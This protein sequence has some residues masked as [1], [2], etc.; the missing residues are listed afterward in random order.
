[1]DGFSG[2]VYIDPRPEL[3]QE[4]RKR[5]REWT[6]R[7]QQLIKTSQ[8]PAFTRDNRRVEVFANAG[9]L[10]DA[11]AAVQNGAEGIGLLRT[12]FLFLTRETPPDEAEQFS[13]LRE[14]IGIMGDRPVTVRTLDVG[15]D[16][17]LPFINLA[18]E[19]NPFLGVRAI[20]MSLNQP[21]LFL[22]QLRA[23]LRASEQ[24]KVRIMFPMISLLDEVRQAHAWLE[25]AHQAL[26]AENTPHAWPVETGIMVEVPSAA[27]LSQAFAQE[28]SFFSIGTNDLTQYTLA[29]ERGNP[30]LAGLSDA[31]HPAVLRLIKEVTTAAHAQGKWVGV[32]GELAG[33]TEAAA[34]LVGLGVDE[35]SLN[36]A[37]IPRIKAVLRQIDAE[38]AAGLADKVIQAASA[39]D[40]RRLARDFMKEMSLSYPSVE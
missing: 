28:V 8:Q 10:T 34:V 1:M 33:D 37:G 40:A 36:P 17:P 19:D 35:L 13:A 24:F 32:C 16:K 31:M 26:L 39:A 3:L 6:E 18:K 7:Q 11:R 5:R 12:E 25:N 22:T 2:K 4:L 21:N 30:I 38:Q 14:I 23:I 15:G 27:L 29:A 20:R 9:N